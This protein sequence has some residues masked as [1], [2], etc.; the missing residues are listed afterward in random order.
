MVEAADIASN[1]YDL[2][3]NRYKEVVYE[4][5][6]YEDPKVILGKLMALENDIMVDLKELEGML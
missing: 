2:S 5:E 1:K 4:E 6:V 3:I